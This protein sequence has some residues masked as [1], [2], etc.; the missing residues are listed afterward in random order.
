MAYPVYHRAF[1]LLLK[2]DFAAALA[3]YRRTLELS[4]RGFFTATQAVDMLAR[5]AAGEALPRY[6]MPRPTRRAMMR[7][8]SWSSASKIASPWLLL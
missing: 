4:P 7:W 6:A 5:E 2:H 3:D 1:T 8:W